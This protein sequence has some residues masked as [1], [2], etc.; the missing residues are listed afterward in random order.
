MVDFGDLPKEELK[1]FII[2]EYHD[3]KGNRLFLIK[4]KLPYNQRTSYYKKFSTKDIPHKYQQNNTLEEASDSIRNYL[5][6]EMGIVP[7]SK[8]YQYYPSLVY[9]FL[10]KLKQFFV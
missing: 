10:K 4:K 7:D 8:K 1:K 3:E 5:I 2:K 9:S 6:E